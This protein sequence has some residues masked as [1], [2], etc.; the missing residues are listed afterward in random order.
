MYRE[1][2]YKCYTDRRTD[3]RTDGQTDRHTDG[4]TDGRVCVC[5]SEREREANNCINRNTTIQST[6]KKP[7]STLL[8]P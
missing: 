4:R 2:L 8:E 7:I 6:H 1:V 3:G 5:V